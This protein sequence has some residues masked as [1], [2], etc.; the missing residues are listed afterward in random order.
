M[1][2]SEII[3]YLTANLT[4]EEYKQASIK[5]QGRILYELF[6]DC[7]LGESEDEPDVEVDDLVEN[8]DG[9]AYLNIRMNHDTLVFYAQIGLLKTLEEAA[10]KVLDENER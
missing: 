9:S 3:E 2:E 1:R 7:M 4:S 10:R 6:V 5:D 8:D